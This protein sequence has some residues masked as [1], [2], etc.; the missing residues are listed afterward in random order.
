MKVCVVSSCGGHLTEVRALIPAYGSFDHFYV[1]NDH[2]TLPPDMEGRTHFIVHSERDLKLLIN[3]WEA[4]RILLK[5][6]PTVILSTGAGPAVPFSWVGKLLFGCKVVFVE[7]FT[8]VD[9]PSLTAR[10][11]YPVADAFFYQWE[12]QSKYFP[13]GRFGGFIL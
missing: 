3:I 8:R 11:I 9:R 1:L 7:T 13:R 4:F 5:E 2:T 10:L 6:R 12:N